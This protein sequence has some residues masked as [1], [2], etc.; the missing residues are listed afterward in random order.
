MANPFDLT[1]YTTSFQNVPDSY[2]PEI[3]GFANFPNIFAMLSEQIKMRQAAMTVGFNVPANLLLNVENY[4]ISTPAATS[5]TIMQF[6]D[7]I[8]QMVN[9]SDLLV[10]YALLTPGCNTY[11]GF[12]SYVSNGE[13]AIGLT[14]LF[15]PQQPPQIGWTVSPDP[16][17]ITNRLEFATLVSE[18]VNEIIYAL[19]VLRFIHS[20]MKFTYNISDT[21][22][23]GSPPFNVC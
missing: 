4:D 6:Q 11:T 14:S 8:S 20:P 16:N 21:C 1:Q 12:F 22:S 23:P 15:P 19:N 10:D 9:D 17:E 3:Y 18:N 2:L 13:P 7:A 5:D